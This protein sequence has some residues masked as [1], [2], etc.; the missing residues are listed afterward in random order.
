MG[1]RENG[2]YWPAGDVNFPSDVAKAGDPF[3]AGSFLP[4]GN[5]DPLLGTLGQH[6]LPEGGLSSLSRTAAGP[7]GED[8][9]PDSYRL[10]RDARFEKFDISVGREDEDR[11]DWSTSGL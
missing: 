7:R 1:A 3:G 2:N 6:S 5:D 10:L 4:A 8:F 11:L 9:L